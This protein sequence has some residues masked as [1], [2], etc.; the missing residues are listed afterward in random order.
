MRTRGGAGVCDGRGAGIA[1][2]C[3]DLDRVPPRLLDLRDRARR[4]ERNHGYDN[5]RAGYGHAGRSRSG[6]SGNP[7]AG[8]YSLHPSSTGVLIPR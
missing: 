5:A 7:A 4:V 6:V 3:G 1:R 2:A 8:D